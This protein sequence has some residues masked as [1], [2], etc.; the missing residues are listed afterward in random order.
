MGVTVIRSGDYPHVCRSGVWDEY[1]LLDGSRAMLN[2]LVLPSGKFLEIS[3]KDVALWTDG[4]YDMKLLNKG[5]TI[6]RAFTALRLFA[7]DYVRATNFVSSDD[8]MYCD[9]L[10]LR[11]DQGKVAIANMGQLYTKNDNKLY[12]QDGAGAEHEVAFAP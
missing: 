1:L 5:G 10:F 6:L 8:E 12:F 11:E 7:S 3:D 9:G 2:T 4:S